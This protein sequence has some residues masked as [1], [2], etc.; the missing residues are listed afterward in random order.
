MEQLESF[1]LGALLLGVLHFFGDKFD[2]RVMGISVVR[3]C[4]FSRSVHPSTGVGVQCYSHPQSLPQSLARARTQSQSQQSYVQV[5]GQMMSHSRANDTNISYYDHRNNHNNDDNYNNN[6][7]V[8]NNI[9]S[10]QGNYVSNDSILNSQSLN[11][12]SSL[13]SS[14][15]PSSTTS[16]FGAPMRQQL[17][18]IPT[19]ADRRHSFQAN[20]H[21]ALHS[22]RDKTRKFSTPSPSTSASNS[23]STSN[24]FRP[25]NILPT[26]TN[27][28]NSFADHTGFLS[29]VPYK[30]DPLFIEDPLNPGNNVGRNCF[31]VLQVQKSWN[32]VHRQMTQK[33]IASARDGVYYSILDFLVGELN[34]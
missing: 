33:L 3:K 7:N 18:M 34:D 11:M 28:N 32:D 20:E 14:S 16:L 12:S 8:N 13:S 27:R 1:D 10:V 19:A 30:F 6:R 31:R 24:N 5:G 23:T 25:N 15:T 4:Y 21:A 29:Y 17:V 22:S 9:S 26:V 2:P